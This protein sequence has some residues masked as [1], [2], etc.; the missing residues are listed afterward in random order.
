MLS[1]VFSARFDYW[2]LR[3]SGHKLHVK[4]D[5]SMWQ[6]SGMSLQFFVLQSV[7]IGSLFFAPFLRRKKLHWP[8][9]AYSQL[10][11]LISPKKVMLDIIST[12]AMTSLMHCFS[13][14]FNRI[15]I[16]SSCLAVN[17][18]SRI[19]LLFDLVGI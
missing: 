2:E 8:S 18:D 16:S 9:S 17:L 14:F 4:L 1:S 7:A 11:F 13:R 5:T 19:Q 3:H 10:V 15:F 12:S 6:C